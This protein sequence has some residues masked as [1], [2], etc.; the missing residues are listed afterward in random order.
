MHKFHNNT[1][2]QSHNSLFQKIT[3]TQMSCSHEENPI[4]KGALAWSSIPQH[5]RSS[6]YGKFSICVWYLFSSC[7]Q[8]IHHFFF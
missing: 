2:P 6:S 4:Y 1:L 8:L 5:F 3:A 7:E